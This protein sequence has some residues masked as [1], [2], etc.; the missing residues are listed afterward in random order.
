[1]KYICECLIN[2]KTGEP[3]EIELPEGIPLEDIKMCGH[4]SGLRMKAGFDS[5]SKMETSEEQPE[6]ILTKQMGDHWVACFLSMGI[7][8]IGKTEAD[9]IKGVE[10]AIKTHTK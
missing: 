2:S 7:S 10:D 8:C 5:A 3:L 9:A 4:T 6:K 1:M